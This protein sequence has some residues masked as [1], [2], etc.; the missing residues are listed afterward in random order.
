MDIAE[1]PVRVVGPGSQAGNNAEGPAYI[2][3][4]SDMQQYDAPIMPEP[5]DVQHLEGASEAMA[6]LQGALA[7]FGNDKAAPLADLTHL[8]EE[9]R[10]LVNQ[11]IGE[12]EVS[13]T[14]NGTPK[15][16]VQESVLAG[17]WRTFYFD[18]D[19]KVAIDL[20]EV[21]HVPHHY[22]CRKQTAQSIDL[23]TIC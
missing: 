20:L 16:H 5:E 12:G 1:I 4:P 9:S 22:C 8:D 6:F 11:I 18:D 23:V 2:D 13:I 7:A 21:G 10:T 19:G 14:Y 17:V 15:A 3:M